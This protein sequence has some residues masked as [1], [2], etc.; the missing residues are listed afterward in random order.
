MCSE[1]HPVTCSLLLLSRNS[2]TS[3]ISVCFLQFFFL[4][5]LNFLFFLV[6]MS[7]RTA[8]EPRGHRVKVQVIIFGGVVSIGCTSTMTMKQ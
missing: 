8:G 7:G 2:S 6:S 1:T 3:L 4:L 5:L